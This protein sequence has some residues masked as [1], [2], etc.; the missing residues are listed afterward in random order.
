MKYDALYIN[1]KI[2]TSDDER[3]YAQA[4]AVKDGRIAWIGSEAEAEAAGIAAESAMVI[5]LGAKRVLPGF[6]DCHMHAIMRILPSRSA[7]CRRRFILL[8]T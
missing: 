3:P 4:M 7:C 6:V 8:K 1:G 5:D 2:F